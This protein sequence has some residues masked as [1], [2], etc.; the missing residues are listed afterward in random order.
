MIPAFDSFWHWLSWFTIVAAAA[1]FR[2]VTV[3][4]KS[5]SLKA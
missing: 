1:T 3:R 5:K 4:A 2:L